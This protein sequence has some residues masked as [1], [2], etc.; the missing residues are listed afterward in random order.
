MIITISGVA[1][2]GKDTIG[3]LLG[4]KLKLPVVKGTLKDYAKER[5][6]ELDIL[7]FERDYASEEM[8]NELDNWQKRQ[9]K[10]HKKKGCILISMMS[11]C[12][13]PK[14]DLKVWLYAPAGERAKRAA[15]RDGIPK[16]R[17]L[18][19]INDRDE[20][21]RKRMKRTYKVDWWDPALYDL[22][23]NTGNWR[24][25]DTVGVIMEAAKRKK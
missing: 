19:Y 24:V 9:V 4:E 6:Y 11:A 18:S 2:S 16:G 15:K 12:N 20:E 25:E 7:E 8:D 22:V 1:V 3:N 10:K 23:V 13:I 21:F 5:G 14:A 17:A